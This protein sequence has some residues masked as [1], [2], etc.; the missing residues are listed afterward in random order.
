MQAS[1]AAAGAA[2]ERYR[3]GVSDG[4]HW[5]SAMLA[6]QLNHLVTDRKIDVGTF[7]R[8]DDYLVNTLGGRK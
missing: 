8:L 6:T 5:C 7:V 2:A 1:G 4:A 3:L